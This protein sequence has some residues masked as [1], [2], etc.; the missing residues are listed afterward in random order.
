MEALDKSFRHL[1]REDKLNTLVQKGWLNEENK[2]TLLNNPLI[3][4]EIA[5][6]LIENVIGQGTL[7]VGLF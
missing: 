1:S 2:N 3:P 6:S 7:P 5:N 4:E